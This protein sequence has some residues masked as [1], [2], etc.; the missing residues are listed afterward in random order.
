M[1]AR[2]RAH[3]H[4]HTDIISPVLTTVIYTVVIKC[5]AGTLE[6]DGEKTNG[7][8]GGGGGDTTHTHTHTHTQGTLATSFST[9]WGPFPNDSAT[10]AIFCLVTET[11]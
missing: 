4:A 10:I 3:A 11:K 9:D 7:E 8:W 1:L 5:T 2:G 6:R